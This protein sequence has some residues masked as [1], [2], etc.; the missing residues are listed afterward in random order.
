M[1]KPACA[2]ATAVALPMPESDPVTTARRR[3]AWVPLSIV[4]G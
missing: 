1:S 3:A 4:T 2:S